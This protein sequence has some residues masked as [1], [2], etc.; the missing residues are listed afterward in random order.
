MKTVEYKTTIDIFQE[1][2]G[3]KWKLFILA[4]LRDGAKRPSVLLKELPGIS[5]RILTKELKELI[6]DGLVGRQAFAEVPPRV[7]YHL[8]PYGEQTLPLLS[9]ICDWGQQ[10][11]QQKLANGE[12]PVI[13]ADDIDGLLAEAPYVI[14]RATRINWRE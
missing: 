2:L 9:T 10:H 11:L 1:A 3:G 6:A 7:E 5:Q 8:T 12:Q 4:R 13:V 14:K